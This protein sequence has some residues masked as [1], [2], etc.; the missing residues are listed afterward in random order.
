[1][2]SLSASSTP[3][4][5][6]CHPTNLT[7]ADRI[8]AS[9]TTPPAK[10]NS[11]TCADSR[12]SLQLGGPARRPL[13]TL[14]LRPHLATLQEESGARLQFSRSAPYARDPATQGRRPQGRAGTARSRLDRH[15][16]GPLP[17]RD[18]G[19][20][21]GGRGEDRRGTAGSSGGIVTQPPEPTVQHPA[22]KPATPQGV[23]RRFCR[24]GRVS[25]CVRASAPDI[26]VRPVHT[27]PRLKPSGTRRDAHP[28]RLGRDPRQRCRNTVRVPQLQLIRSS[29]S[30]DRI[31]PSGFGGTV[32]FVASVARLCTFRGR[33]RKPTS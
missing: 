31:G 30:R 11:R 10:P 8:A 20:A 22:T 16:P 9:A 1:M 23:N 12:C 29:P 19:H 6:Q 25:R 13:A 5:W 26:D 32:G 4:K 18:A 24:F 14:E 33:G 3:N 17:T 15:H 7:M 27:A 21:G 28:T 2:G